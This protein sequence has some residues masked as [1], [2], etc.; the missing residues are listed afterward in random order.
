MHIRDSFLSVLKKQLNSDCVQ[1]RGA[2]EEG[3]VAHAEALYL[4]IGQTN[5]ALE[6]HQESGNWDAALRFA[7]QYL[8][9]KANPLI[10]LHEP[11]QHIQDMLEGHNWHSGKHLT[12]ASSADVSAAY[13]DLT[14]QRGTQFDHN[15]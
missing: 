9:H 6:M 7:E 5:L 14:V 8:P 3:D 10:W 4:E 11:H 15:M 2:R 13:E 12:T 1:A